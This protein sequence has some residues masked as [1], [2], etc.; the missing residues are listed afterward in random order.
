MKTALIADPSNGKNKEHGNVLVYTVLSTLFL[1]F[2]V[3]L[4]VDLS[5]LYM[6]KAE[7]QNAAD[8]GA[9]AGAKGL[10]HNPVSER[11][12][13]AVDQA[14]NTMNLNKYNFNNKTFAAVMTTADQRTLVTFGKTLDS[15]DEIVDPKT[16]AQAQADADPSTF[17]YVRVSTPSVPVNVFFAS[18]ILGSSQ[19]LNARA[20][21]GASGG[22]GGCIYALN[23]TANNALVVSS[24]T[25]N[26][27]CGV[28]VDSSSSSG[29]A[30]SGS[31]NLTAPVISVVQTSCSQC[32]CVNPS[33]QFGQ[34][35]VVD[36]LLYL[37]PP[38][39]GACPPAIPINNGTVLDPGV[40]CGGITINSKTGV[41]FNP[42]TYILNGGGLT[43]HGG[44][45]VSGAGVTFYNT[46]TP[47]TWAYKPID[48]SSSGGTLTAPTTGPLAGILFFQD[49]ANTQKAVISGGN[50][51]K[52]EGALYFPTAILEFSGASSSVSAYL[53]LVAA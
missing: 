5:H 43:I 50:I 18:P 31:C 6:A 2:A 7:L 29:L 30:A 3:G 1:F 27:Q 32:G 52:L 19:T 14:V 11:I 10:Q 21:A 40:Y 26:V 9:L 8:A 42:G 45:T 4:G 53:V 34:P 28:F 22:N 16:E 39:V 23:P 24:S 35:A 25:V 46:G 13:V 36:P 37:Q 47:G 49:P 17:K 38:T 12:Q 41:K 48:I 51:L 20:I 44:S 33:P 15:S